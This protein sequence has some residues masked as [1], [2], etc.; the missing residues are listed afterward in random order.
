MSI[1]S[2]PLLRREGGERIR[3]PAGSGPAGQ[4]P[5]HGGS[6]TRGPARTGGRKVVPAHRAP[7][8]EIGPGLL[9]YLPL[10]VIATLSVTVLPALAANWIV[11][12]HGLPGHLVAV[13][14]AMALSLA[15]AAAE[16]RIWKRI[17]G[18]RAL[19]FGDLML[20][21]FVRRLS[22]ER[23]LKRAGAAYRA[24]VGK[25][26]L[27]RVEL[28]EGLSHL[29]EIRNPYTYGHCRRVARHCERIARAMHVG[30]A[31]VAEIRTAA[32]IH[33]VGKVYTPTAILHKEGPLDE[34]EFEVV[35]R[36]SIDGADML[37]PV[38]DPQLASIVRHHHERLDGSGYPDGLKG[39]EIP[40]GARIIAVAD[41]F[42]AITSHRPYRRARSQQEALAVLG[43]EAAVLLDADVVDAFVRSYSPR[44]Q[45]ASMSLS[46]AVSARL[47][48]ALQLLPSS[49]LGGASLAGVLPAIGAAGL[50]AVAPDARY[51]RTASALGSG[52]GALQ[53]VFPGALEGRG[54]SGGAVGTGQLKARTAPLGVRSPGAGHRRGP[55]TTSPGAGTPAASGQETAG[56]WSAPTG[57]GTPS[58]PGGPI[59]VPEAPVPPVVRNPPPAGVPPVNVPPVKAPPVTTPSVGTP[60]VSVGPVTVPGVTVPSVTVQAPATPGVTLPGVHIGN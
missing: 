9:P 51:E 49:L 45:I 31:E 41:T 39:E 4:S 58:S 40:L 15:I 5:R 7:W 10:S 28:L 6:R 43:A 24:A 52:Q 44:R 27:V 37:A 22:A 53:A 30:P 54:G 29:L 42:D 13:V 59:E 26:C 23:R 50:L 19:V 38:R 18:P 46:T 47:A 14:C 2:Q 20:W 11:P 36:H 16:A 55:A 12:L 25:D 3:R 57:P 17:H 34:D 48:T 60:P 56:A 33:D 1:S 35:K 8:H 32:L 21:T